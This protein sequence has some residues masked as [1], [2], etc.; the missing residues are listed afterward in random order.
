MDGW[1]DGIGM[2]RWDSRIHPCSWL[3]KLI[4]FSAF[5]FLLVNFSQISYL[6][7]NDFRN[8]T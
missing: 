7:K 5:I 8:S 4:V 3:K 6:E 2:D 1:M